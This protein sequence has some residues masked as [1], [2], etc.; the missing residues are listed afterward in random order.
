[1]DFVDLAYDVTDTLPVKERFLL[2]DQL[3]RSAVSIPSNIAEGSKRGTRADFRN[4]SRIAL[5]SAAEAETQLI[6]ITRRY[7]QIPCQSALDVIT[8]I[9]KMLT[10]L[11]ASLGKPLSTTTET[12]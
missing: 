10:S 8:E 9:E 6:I 4:F 11:I 2:I 12:L 3:R 5:G 1:M 7:P